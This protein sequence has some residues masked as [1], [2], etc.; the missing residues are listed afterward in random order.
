M[1]L[2]LAE[3]C[4]QVFDTS[5]DSDRHF[6]S[7]LVGIW[8]WIEGGT[9]TAV[10]YVRKDF[11]YQNIPFTDFLNLSLELISLEEDDEDSLIHWFTLNKR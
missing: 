2:C 5:H 10:L 9:E 6:A 8:T 3:N 1:I 7:F 11:K 4:F